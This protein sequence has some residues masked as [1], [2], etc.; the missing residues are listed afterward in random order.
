V[1]REAGTEVRAQEGRHR[2]VQ[3]ARGKVI[4][5]GG[6]STTPPPATGSTVQAPRI[7]V[8]IASKG[9]I[10]VGGSLVDD[11]ALP[12]KLRALATRNKDTQL[13]IEADKSVPYARVVFVLDHAKRAGLTLVLLA[14]LP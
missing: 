2:A 6:S 14:T 10:L 8:T 9:E 5:G 3:E 12:G 7:I 4:S 11:A 13:L 1:P